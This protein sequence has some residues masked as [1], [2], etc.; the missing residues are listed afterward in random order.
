M[1]LTHLLGSRQSALALS[2]ISEHRSDQRQ[3]R[4]GGGI[5]A[6]DA[7]S[8][9]EPHH[10]GQLEQRVALVGRRSR[11]PDRPGRQAGSARCRRR[12]VR[13][14]AQPSGPSPRRPRRR[15]PGGGPASRSAI[16]WSNGQRCA[17]LRE[18]QDAALLGGLDGVGAHAVEIDARDLGMPG[19]HRL[20][21]GR[22]HLDGLLHHVVEAGMLE[23]R[24]QVMQIECAGLGPRA[25]GR[26]RS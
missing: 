8:E 17:D 13:P 21:A 19:D 10:I 20:Q 12:V 16:M 18:R 3:R 7:G 1:L 14:P 24:E 2:P 5:G 15:R 25:L 11:P 26:C 22:P 23:R 9:R 4:D 6:Q